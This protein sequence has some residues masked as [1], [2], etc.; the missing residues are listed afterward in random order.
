MRPAFYS[1]SDFPALEQLSRHWR[2]VREEFLALDLPVL[3]IDRVNKSHQE[4]YEE[5]LEHLANGG[6]GGWVLGWD[7][8][9]GSEGS[10]EANPDWLS[11]GLVVFDELVP[12]ASENM[13]RSCALFADL[14]GIKTA[15]L[16]KMQPHLLL[17]T[18]RHPELERENLLQMHQAVDAAEE[19]NYAYLNVAG[20]FFQHNMGEACIFD[21]SLDHF[22]LNASTQERTI[23]YLEFEKDRYFR[24]RP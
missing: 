11:Y 4:V 16:V 18:H 13:P 3:D 19:G 17:T 20:E 5:F 21:G 1:L 10:E 8:D 24:P 2:V 22:A 23:L 15:A 12:G 6:R 14:Q 9:Q 7:G